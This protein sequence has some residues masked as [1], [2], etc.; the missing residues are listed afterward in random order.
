MREGNIW[1]R[2]KILDRMLEEKEQSFIKNVER[3]RG[4]DLLRVIS[5]VEKKQ[6]K[7]KEI[8]AEELEPTSSSFCACGGCNKEQINCFPT[9]RR[10]NTHY[11]YAG[12]V[13]SDKE[14]KKLE[15][16]V[17]RGEQVEFDPERNEVLVEANMNRDSHGL[18]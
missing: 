7:N 6:F 9:S 14:Y 2:L 16:K 1:L 13:Y 12:T 18:L 8:E 5:K 3:K 15:R 4:T 17:G 10:E 11:R